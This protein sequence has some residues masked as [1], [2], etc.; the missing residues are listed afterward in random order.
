VAG[1]RVAEFKATQNRFQRERED[2]KATMAKVLCW[3]FLVVL[4]SA[5]RTV[6]CS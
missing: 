1:S 3:R 6:A 2:Y 5:S 4:L